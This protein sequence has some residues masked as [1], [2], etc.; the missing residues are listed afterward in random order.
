VC[1]H[2]AVLGLVGVVVLLLYLEDWFRRRN[3]PPGPIRFPPLGNMP[4]LL[5]ADKHVLQ[6]SRPI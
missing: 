5:L 3:F 4:Q 1:W 6:V 2:L